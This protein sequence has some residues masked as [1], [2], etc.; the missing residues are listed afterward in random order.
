VKSY[1]PALLIAIENPQPEDQKTK[2]T[3]MCT[4]IPSLKARQQ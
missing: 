2:T 3:T 4:K 1:L